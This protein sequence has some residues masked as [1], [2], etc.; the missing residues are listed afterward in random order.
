VA[1]PLHLTIELDIDEREV[2]GVARD[3]HGHELAFVGWL[4][5]A[6]AVDQLRADAAEPLDL[7][8]SPEEKP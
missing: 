5:L 8:A 2:Q 3:R 6:G 7:P 1:R 4:G